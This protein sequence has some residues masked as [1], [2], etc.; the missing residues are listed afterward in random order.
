MKLSEVADLLTMASA[1]DGRK[2]A[3]TTVEA[4]AAALDDNIAFADAKA[5]VIEHYARTRD[6]LMPADVNAASRQIRHARTSVIATPQPP[7]ALDGIPAREHA[8]RRAYIRLVGDG[9]TEAEADA[10]ACAEHGVTRPAIE[11][12][13][14][15]VAALTGTHKGGCTCGCLTRP[16]RAEERR[17]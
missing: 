11:A 16:I 5:I 6:W 15:P 3:V 8:W 12:A 9:L 13:P 4:W 10:Q 7:E 17:A 14:R 2:P 1:Y